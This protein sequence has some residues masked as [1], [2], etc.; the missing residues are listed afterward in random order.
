[1]T[2]D[3]YSV[4]VFFHVLFFAYW[5]GP[6][7]G[8]FV[9]GRR[10]ADETLSREERLRF[11]VAS[12]AIDILPRTC[13]V[14]LVAVG[15]TLGQQGGFIHLSSLAL[16]LVWA[17]AFV[18]VGL[19]LLTGYLLKPGDLKRRLDATHIWLRHLLV[20]VFAVMG[21]YS[22]VVGVPIVSAWLAI[23]FLLVAALLVCGSVLRVIVSQ[24]V[25]ELTGEPR[26]QGKIA[27]TYPRTRKIVYLFWATTIA[28]A[29]LGVTKPF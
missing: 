10:V 11:L 14:L 3:G 24:W 16:W 28:I 29:F 26:Y 23:K 21:G 7:W 17:I 5:L 15:F 18:W 22:L 9:N 27:S 25:K 12:V 20:V 1:M 19:V 13:I 2:V 4:L 6:D 8:V